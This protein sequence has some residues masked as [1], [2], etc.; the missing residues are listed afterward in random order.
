MGL[1]TISRNHEHRRVVTRG[2]ENAVIRGR[3]QFIGI[4]RFTRESLDLHVVSSGEPDERQKGSL[5]VL[6]SLQGRRS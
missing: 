4:L 2:K 6:V 1:P 5:A 3:R